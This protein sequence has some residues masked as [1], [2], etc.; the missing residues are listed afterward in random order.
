[1]IHF[2]SISWQNFLSTGNTPIKIDL[3]RHPTNLIIGKNGSGKS[4][5]L[6]A[7]CFVL[8]NKPF[9][10]IKKEQMVN[11]INDSDCVVE[12]EFSV[13]TKN[14]KVIRSVKPNK[15]EIYKDGEL[16][17]QD[18]STIDYQKYLERNIMKLNYRSFIQVVLLGSSSYEP[19]MKMKSRYRR[20]AVEEILDVRVFTL[21][22]YNLRDKQRD[23]GKSVSDLRH[24]CDLIEQKV[25]LQGEHLKSLKT[26]IGDAEASYRS[27]IEQN[28][29]ADRQYRQD[30]QQLNEDIAKQQEIMKFKPDVDK[31]AKKLS[32]LE[33]KIQNNLDTHKETLSFFETHDECP[34]C[35][36]DIPK[37]LKSKKVEEEKTTITKLESG[38]QDIMQEIT[39]VESQITEMDAVSKKIQD[40]NISIAK[41]NSSLEGIKKHSDDIE[42]STADG[43]DS[44]KLEQELNDL[45][46]ELKKQKEELDKLSTEK[47]YVDVLREILSDKGARAQ[48][49]KK[50]LPIMNQLINKYLQSMDFFVSFTLDEEFNET[51]KS[52]FR[53]TFN[54]NNFSEGEKMRIDLALLFTWR[55][56]ARMKNSTNTNLLILDEIFDSSLDG[57]GTD[58]FFKIIKTLEKENIFIISHKGDILFDKFT[59]I[60]KFEKNQNFT[61]LG[62]I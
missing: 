2:K 13:G 57:Q 28:Q 47:D 16:V 49:I 44:D 20:E 29:E 6:D 7:L 45:S 11:T 33:S 41:I 18:A 3:D 12:I 19:F 38:L 61:Q 56:I 24:S 35:T 10:I 40:M 36:Q 31:K 37:D 42:L 34:T 46:E 5:L 55:D 52:R 43:Q 4:T 30:L 48:I 22:D 8:F 23:L 9:R 51:V 32:K 53:D 21:M 25:A 17:N 14:Y 54:Y 62:T 15:F 39:K 50:Y 27:K 26:R 1:M 60:I 58:D 59:N